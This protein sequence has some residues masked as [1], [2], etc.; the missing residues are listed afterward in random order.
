M[1]MQ[2]T[3]S[4]S[5][6]RSK[7]PIRKSKRTRNSSA[8][9]FSAYNQEEMDTNNKDEI[10]ESLEPIDQSENLLDLETYTFH[11]SVIQNL[12]SNPITQALAKTLQTIHRKYPDELPARDYASLMTD[13]QNIP[14]EDRNRETELEHTLARK[15]E[16]IEIR[17]SQTQA[18]MKLINE[19]FKNMET[20]LD[21]SLGIDEIQCYK[22][23][24][25]IKVHPPKEF[26]S[27]DTMNSNA[28]LHA[29]NKFFPGQVYK[30]DGHN[31]PCAEFLE[32]VNQ[33]QKYLQLTRAEF[34]DCLL[35]AT[36]GHPRKNI[37]L[38]I[39]SNMS[40]DSIYF[41]LNHMYKAGINSEE[42]RRKLYNYVATKN[43]DFNV[44][45][46][47]ISILAHEAFAT[48]PNENERKNTI[49]REA[50]QQ[51]IKSTPQTTSMELNSSFNRLL[52]RLGKAP[53][54]D[55][56]VNANWDKLEIIN[57]D[58]RAN[59][60]NLRENQQMRARKDFGQKYF[61]RGNVNM[62]KTFNRIGRPQIN[63]IN[64]SHG[65]RPTANL[66]I[67]GPQSRN[68]RR[69]ESNFHPK[70]RDRTRES[71]FRR[72][73][74]FARTGKND[75]QNNYQS[76]YNDRERKNNGNAGRSDRGP[77][78][79]FP[80]NRSSSNSFPRNKSSNSGF[81][82]NRSVSNT[83]FK[84]K[85]QN[86]SPMNKNK[87]S[88]SR[89]YKNDIEKRVKFQNKF[90]TL[91]GYTNHKAIDGCRNMI[92]DRGAIVENVVPISTKCPECLKKGKSL[93]HPVTL[94]PWRIPN[95][96]FY[97]RQK[98]KNNY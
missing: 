69:E 37:S 70:S 57:A 86:G 44:V 98:N 39:Q 7:T 30:W 75:A 10:E 34:L 49:D 97:K 40:I 74:R 73:N 61:Q 55:Q 9:D 6:G 13:L 48:I 11:P 24:P 14:R 84:Y 32:S 38:W 88:E 29:I 35:H 22:D 28:K 80:R 52:R 60:A 21:K 33:A 83:S 47:N 96:I 94:C 68:G 42:A 93:Q 67:L 15:L 63:Q 3:P 54:L 77:S 95:G 53:T 16:E 46:S 59:G 45:V 2:R 79:N 82:R 5:R 90:C 89:N 56:L 25:T 18:Q 85:N 26:S 65:D 8:E 20:T 23:N 58:I 4:V 1:Q 91:C 12:N 19:S 72:H 78:N 92:S 64:S 66:S 50:I 51:L 71:E 62:N 27:F 41:R 81:N 76:S 36:T 87:Y 31:I 17:D 43:K